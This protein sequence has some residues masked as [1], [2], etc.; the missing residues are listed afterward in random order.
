MLWDQRVAHGTAPNDSSRARI[1][2]FV[3]GF[4]KSGVSAGRARRRSERVRLEIQRAGAET[5]AVVSDL[6]R[7]LFGLE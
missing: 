1:A 2:Q 3:K 5:R 4:R 7:K 6:G